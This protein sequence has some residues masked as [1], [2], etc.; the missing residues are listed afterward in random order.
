MDVAELVAARRF[1]L[2]DEQGSPRAEL[3]TEAD[4]L[5]GVHVYGK[6]D[7]SASVSIGMD[8]ETG[9]P[10]VLVQGT[11]NDGRSGGV[12]LGVIQGEAAIRLKDADGTARNIFANE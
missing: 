1:V 4:G 8:D 9:T 12:M 3:T 5:V 10:T 6:G 2:V 11:A 7:S